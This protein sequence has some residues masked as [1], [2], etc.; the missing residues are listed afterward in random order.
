[1]RR[2]GIKV[3]EDDPEFIGPI[4]LSPEFT[5]ARRESWHHFISRMHSRLASNPVLNDLY[6]PKP[7]SWP[8]SKAHWCGNRPGKKWIDY[9]EWERRKNL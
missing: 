2:L 8:K 6:P 7:H 3:T 9:P 5:A 4:D 1:M